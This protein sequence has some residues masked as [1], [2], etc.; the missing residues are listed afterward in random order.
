[1]VFIQILFLDTMIYIAQYA[2]LKGHVFVDMADLFIIVVLFMF[3]RIHVL[4]KQHH[5]EG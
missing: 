5:H 4:W 1:M 3:M 2:S